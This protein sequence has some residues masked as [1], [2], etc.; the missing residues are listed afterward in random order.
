M[1]G[2]VSSKNIEKIGA[3]LDIIFK[4]SFAEYVGY[5]CDIDF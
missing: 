4:N 5:V 1:I 2:S 3:G